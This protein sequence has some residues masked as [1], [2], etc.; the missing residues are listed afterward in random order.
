MIRREGA[1]GAQF[2]RFLK[3]DILSQVSLVA[4]KKAIVWHLDNA[5][6]CP[7]SRVFLPPGCA[8]AQGDM[9]G[10]GKAVVEKFWF[11]TGQQGSYHISRTLNNLNK[12]FF[13]SHRVTLYR[14]DRLSER[15]GIRAKININF[16]PCSPQ[17]RQLMIL[18][19]KF[20]PF[21]FL[22]SF[23]HLIDIRCGCLL[24]WLSNPQSQLSN[25]GISMPALQ[26]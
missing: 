13:H 3:D 16:L 19:V 26:K 23:Y 7:N 8:V 15:G 14:V 9:Y 25:C 4:R 1:A 2:R 12:A 22:P 5:A 6:T 10:L 24:R 21:F 20:T 11:P 17:K 18:S